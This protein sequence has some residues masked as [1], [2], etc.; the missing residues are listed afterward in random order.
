LLGI[1]FI[2]RDLPCSVDSLQPAPIGQL[3]FSHI[4]FIHLF[5][6]IYILFFLKK[7]Y[8]VVPRRRHALLFSWR[9]QNLKTAKKLY[10]YHFTTR[11]ARNIVL[12]FLI[13]TPGT[14]PLCFWS[15]D[16]RICWRA[17]VLFIFSLS[18]SVLAFRGDEFWDHSVLVSCSFQHGVL[19]TTTEAW[20]ILWTWAF[21]YFF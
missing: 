3:L 13:R 18:Y 6:T 9:G 5:I 10:F 20:G 17:D 14:R 8:G 11:D 12:S 15:I 2:P 16:V 19:D 21:Y 4:P 7:K 1:P